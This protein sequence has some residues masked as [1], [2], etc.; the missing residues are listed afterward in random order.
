MN[1]EDLLKKISDLEWEDFEAKEAKS[2]VPKSSWET[3]SAFSNTTGGWLVFGVKQ[4]GKEF[5][6]E[7]V[8]NSEK[9]ESDFLGV[10]R[11]EKF[12]VFISP[13]AQRYNFEGKIV[14]A[15][16]I[17]PSGK[18]PVYYN[19]LSN[20]YIRKGSS[21]QKATKEEIDYMYRD[22]T[23][24]VKTSETV[25]GTSRNDLNNTSVSRYRDYMRRFN[26]DVSYNRFDEEEFLNKLR[27][28]EDGRCTYSGLLMLGKRDSIER[29]FSDFRIDLL[30]IPGISYKDS[31]ARYT[32]RLDEHENLWEYYFECFA[33]LKQ[34]VDVSFALHSEGFGQEL[35]P[36]L[37]AVREALVN[38]LMHADYFS[39][40]HSRVRIFTDRIE[41]YNPG[42]LPK[43]FE[44]LKSK[45][46][47]M[48][49]NPIISKLFRMV[50]LAENA[51]FGFDKIESNW[52]KYNKT[53][54]EYDLA[55]DSLIIKLNLSVETEQ[56]VPQINYGLKIEELRVNHASFEEFLR[57]NYGLKT[58]NL[59]VKYSDR[60]LEILLSIIQ[61]ENVRKEDIS[62]RLDVSISTVEKDIK[63]LTDDGI[64]KR[65]GSRKYGRW[66]IIKQN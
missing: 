30:E 32:F 35:S 6:I 65:E 38:M 60:S 43:P 58:E 4:S 55:F 16:Y 9:M 25:P 66:V 50:K 41:F 27:V 29:H 31:D 23:F 5:S 20:T 40:A 51:G 61:N 56:P 19:S 53:L 59:R 14:L 15:F 45:D 49:R 47:S 10:L 63:E 11:S 3:V 18:K 13:T 28:I 26:P 48:P 54:P 33:R 42:G 2:E 57:G 1:K 34:K 12:N 36:G 37:E 44:E 8:S 39:P 17:P 22:Q 21:D 62:V 7:G 46:I 64:I 24:G 52:L